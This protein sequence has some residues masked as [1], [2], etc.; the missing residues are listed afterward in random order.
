LQTDTFLIYP[1]REKDSLLIRALA[2]FMG[3]PPSTLNYLPKG[4]P[5]YITALGIYREISMNLGRTHSVLD[6]SFRRRR[7]GSF[8]RE[9]LL[10]NQF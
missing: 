7:L 6:A 2:P 9:G 4:S 1:H 5:L 8:L 10:K 3:A